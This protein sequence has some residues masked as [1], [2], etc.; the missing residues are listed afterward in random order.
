VVD[1]DHMGLLANMTRGREPAIHGLGVVIKNCLWC[2]RNM[3][4]F[5]LNTEIHVINTR[6]SSNLHVPLKNLEQIKE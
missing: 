4:L 3:H 2:K 1:I 6:Q 5:V